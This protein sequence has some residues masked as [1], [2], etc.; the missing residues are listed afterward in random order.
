MRSL[1][2]ANARSRRAGF[3]A[4]TY[5]DPTYTRIGP[6]PG[7]A[8]HRHIDSHCNSDSYTHRD[9]HPNSYPHSDPNPDGNC[10]TRPAGL[11]GRIY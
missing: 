10:H 11:S 8:P 1:C 5:P 9:A 7:A 4:N 2:T 6:R 3:I